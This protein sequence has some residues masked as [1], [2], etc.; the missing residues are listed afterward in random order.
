MPPGAVDGTAT[1]ALGV[2]NSSSSDC[3]LEISPSDK[4]HFSV[5]ATLTVD[6]R[7]VSNDQLSKF[8]QATGIPGEARKGW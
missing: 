3:K 2:V 1:V 8:V 6:C 5:A 4:N 7:Y